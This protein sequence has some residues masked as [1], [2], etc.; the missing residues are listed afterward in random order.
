MAVG[1]EIFYDPLSYR[2]HFQNIGQAYQE[3]ARVLI[4]LCRLYVESSPQTYTKNDSIQ[5]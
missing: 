1:E 4:E 3:Q 5:K 2:K